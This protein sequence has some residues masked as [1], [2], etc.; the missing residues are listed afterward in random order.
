MNIKVCKIN[1]WT[2]WESI[3]NGQL[4]VSRW[5]ADKVKKHTVDHVSDRTAKEDPAMDVHDYNY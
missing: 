4:I 2:D 3:N 5:F 1:I